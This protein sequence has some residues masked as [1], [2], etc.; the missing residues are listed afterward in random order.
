VN[1]AHLV[2]VAGI[3]LIALSAALALAGGVAL[4]YGESDALSFM[5]AAAIALAVGL[6]AFRR[7][8]LERDLSIREGYAVVAIS[9][10]VVGLAGATPYLFSGVIESPVAAFFESVSGFTTTG[11]TVFAEVETLPRSI[12][13]WRAMTQWLG[14]MGIVLLGVAI[15]PFL[16]VGGMQ[17]FKA[18]VPGP[19]TE[20]LTPRIRHT[21]TTLWYVY[22]GL[23]ALQTGLYVLGGMPAFDAVLHA[24]TTLSTGGFS[25]MNASLAAYSPYLQYVTIAFMYL[26]AI[27]FTLHYQLTRGRVRYGQDAEWRFFTGVTLAVTALV[28]I[29]AVTGPARGGFEETFRAALFQVTSI[30]TTTGFVTFDYELWGSAAA[31]ALLALMFMGGMAGSTAGGMKAMRVRLL[32]RHGLTELKRSVHP[33][34]VIVAR[35]GRVPVPDRTFYRVM[36]FALFFIG[37]FGAG[38]F[39]MAILGHDLVTAIGASAA[40]IGNIGPGLGG[41]GAVQN[42]GWMGPAS[43]LIL[44]F[45]MLAGRLELFTVLLLFHPDLWRR[46]AKPAIMR[47]DA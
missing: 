15:L 41:V 5:A 25:S 14:G 38:A 11:A 7:T 19:T 20:R 9:W 40:S 26:A 10:I 31:L 47:A 27:N 13:F 35:L 30:V 36:A 1:F 43:H 42:Y 29:L 21:A 8:T 24:F 18:E 4:G 34:A 16:G 2:H 12:L 3:T 32:L 22:A 6:T 39:A 23:T 28:F 33:R 46:H 45:L 44:V 17:L 37:L